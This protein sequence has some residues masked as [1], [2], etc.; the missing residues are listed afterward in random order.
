MGH[1]KERARSRYGNE[2]SFLAHLVRFDLPQ[3]VGIADVVNEQ[4]PLQV[5]DFVL[6]N[7]RQESL[8]LE[9]DPLAS[10][11]QPLH[12]DGGG[13]FLHSRSNRGRGQTT[14]F[15]LFGLA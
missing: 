8:R 7:P 13:P 4:D 3:F 10:A 12:R 11:I 15:P 6:E 14:L 1:G 2:A 9:A 5:I